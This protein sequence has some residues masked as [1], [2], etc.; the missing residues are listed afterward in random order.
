MSVIL[1]K[2]AENES[3]SEPNSI[4]KMSPFWTPAGGKMYLVAFSP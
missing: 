2:Y 4:P 3:H 1:V